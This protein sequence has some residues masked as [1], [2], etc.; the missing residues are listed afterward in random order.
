ML[1]KFYNNIFVVYNITQIIGLGLFI[2]INVFNSFSKYYFMN[3]FKFYFCY[4]GDNYDKVIDS[5]N[6]LL[7]LIVLIL[8]LFFV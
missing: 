7:L 8:L 5:Y 1:Y 6:M 3:L 4:N 2:N